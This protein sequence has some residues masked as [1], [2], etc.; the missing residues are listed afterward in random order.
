MQG[1]LVEDC[2]VASGIVYDSARVL[3]SAAEDFANSVVGVAE[4]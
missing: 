1:S 4:H 3:A 2:S